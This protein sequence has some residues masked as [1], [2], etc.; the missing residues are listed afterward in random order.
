M[1]FPAG[2]QKWHNQESRNVGSWDA[3]D[4]DDGDH[5]GAVNNDDDD[6]SDDDDGN[7]AGADNNDDG[8][9]SD[10]DDAD[11]VGDDDNDKPKKK[12][13]LADIVIGIRG[14]FLR[15]HI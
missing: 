10:D 1:H 4:D 12:L 2:R 8:D 7:D 3:S 5:A 15:L 11:D 14:P 13:K 6:A 9:A